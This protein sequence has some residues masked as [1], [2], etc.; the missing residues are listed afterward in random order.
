MAFVNLINSAL[1]VKRYDPFG[2][3]SLM[4]STI[5]YYL[6]SIVVLTG[7]SLLWDDAWLLMFIIYGMLPYLDEIFSHD[8]RNPN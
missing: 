7:S 5:P 2:K 8:L 3:N 4:F 6:F 1:P